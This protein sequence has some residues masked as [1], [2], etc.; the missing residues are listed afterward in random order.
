MAQKSPN[1]SSYGGRIYGPY[2]HCLDRLR[3]GLGHDETLSQTSQLW[4]ECRC[5]RVLHSRAHSTDMP[6]GGCSCPY[7]SQG[8]IGRSSGR[9]MQLVPSLAPPWLKLNNTHRL[10]KHRHPESL[11]RGM[12][13]WRRLTPPDWDTSPDQTRLCLAHPSR[14]R[15]A[16]CS[17]RALCEP[18]LRTHQT[19][20]I[21]C[22]EERASRIVCD[23]DTEQGCTEEVGRR[24]R[25]PEGQAE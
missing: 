22:E 23:R 4:D 21:D 16:E 11:F 24:R 7:R 8:L 19:A 25:N 2:S 5:G 3:G 12:Q 14:K 20:A 17:Q 1:L 18:F 13:T 9:H 10:N 15:R 6:L